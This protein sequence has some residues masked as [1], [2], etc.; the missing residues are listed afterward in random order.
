M[1][2]SENERKIS[3]DGGYSVRILCNK[4]QADERVDKF[5]GSETVFGSKE[6][7]DGERK[8]GRSGAKEGGFSG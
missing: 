7:L 2:N 4:F 1:G 6:I 8:C 3:E 5:G